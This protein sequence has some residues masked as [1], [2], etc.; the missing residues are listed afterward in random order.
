MMK[1]EKKLELFA[2][3]SIGLSLAGFFLDSDPREPSLL[4]NICEIIIM[5]GIIFMILTA[6][7]FAFKFISNLL[8]KKS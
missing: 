4:I 2:I 7:Y 1:H 6:F 3:L 5:T 8:I